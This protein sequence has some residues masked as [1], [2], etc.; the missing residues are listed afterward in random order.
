MMSS[1]GGHTPE[2]HIARARQA[3]RETHFQSACEHAA[4]GMALVAPDGHWLHVN[5]ALQEL[6]GYDA[7]TL[8]GKTFQDITHPEDVE[9]DLELARRVLAGSMRTYQ[10]EKRYLHADGRIIWVLL[11]VSL[12]RDDDGQ[13]LHFIAQIQDI[14]RAKRALEAAE[15]GHRAKSQFLARMSHELRT[16]LNSIL[17]FTRLVADGLV[18][19]V[20]EQQREYLEIAYRHGKHLLDLV[21]E[22]LDLAELESDKAGLTLEPVMLET[23]IR[24]AIAGVGAE[25]A[26][27][28]LEL[29]V[30]LPTSIAPLRANAGRL[31]Q[32]VLHLLANALKFTERGSVT[33]RVEVDPASHMARRIVVTDTGPGIPA[34]RVEA[35]FS[36]F[37]QASDQVTVRHGGAG[38]GLTISRTLCELMGFRLHAESGDGPGAAFVVTFRPEEG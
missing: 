28:G 19:S 5:R 22:I 21:S 17:G 12:V 8:L 20:T 23:V 14:T 34:D 38:L 9:H 27:R 37:E 33:V 13:P 1:D 24:D 18:G 15:A 6:T 4:I 2:W 7:A 36:A 10:M 16:P 11:S 35:I 26:N 30:E 31:R 29:H 32:V 25:A 3:V